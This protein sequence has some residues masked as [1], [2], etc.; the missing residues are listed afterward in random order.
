MAQFEIRAREGLG[1]LGKLQTKHGA[2]RTPLLMPVIHPG[3]A[4]IRANEMISEFGFQMVIT[5][6]YIINSHER[7]RE[8]ALA[9]G[10][11]ALLDIDCPIMTDSGTF[12][13]YFHDLPK[14][15]IDPI[16]IV[17]FQKEIRTDIGTIL[18][19][20]SAPDVG[21]EQVERDVD[22]SLERAKMSVGIKGEM[23]LAGTIQGGMYTNLREKS[24]QQ[25]GKLNFDVYPIGGV[26]PFMEMYRY[27][28]I[29]R[30]I[31][32]CK[33]YLPPDR[34]VHLFGCGHPML[35]AQAALLGCDLFDS[36]SY[37][38]FAESG[39]MLLTS[40]TVHL[41]GLSELP[42]EC[43]VCSTT[44]AD[45][46]KAL[47]KDERDAA[48]MRHNLY[49]SAAEIRR[50]RQAISDNKLFELTSLRARSH[51]ALLEA[52]E[53]M[54]EEM[55]LLYQQDPM[56]KTS[57]IFYT[58]PETVNRPEIVRFH[59]RIM[60]RYPYW[61]TD[62]IL[63]F[64]DSGGRPFSES[65][66]TIIDFVRKKPPQNLIVL[67]LTPMGVVPWELE[68]VHPAQQCIFPKKVDSNTLQIVENRLLEF[69]KS[70]KFKKIIWFSRE[71][72]TNLI[73]TRLSE[74]TDVIV[75]STASEAL[76]NVES[77]EIEENDWIQRKLR[78]ILRYQW[79]EEAAVL[80]DKGNLTAKISKSTGKIRYV[81]QDGHILFTMVPTNGLLTPTFQGGIEL[82]NLGIDGRYIVRIDDEVRE[83]VAKG[84]SALAKFVVT[85][86][87]KLIAGEECLVVDSEMNLLGVGRALLSGEEM[88]IF[89][90]GVAVNIRHS[91]DT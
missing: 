8:I 23:M 38:K 54:L 69:L 7:F 71:S 10:V 49:V 82:L 52:F 80:A 62:N 48:L 78:V 25:M 59:S 16:S 41:E 5:N 6:S 11:H 3:K 64:P 72:P 75:A 26:V 15:E 21:Y 14:E 90:R 76:E 74:M 56:A 34:P 20:F 4:I 45:D 66:S 33:K 73:L 65:A 22:L 53:T 30:I 67:F 32:A 9:N 39:R 70:M 86:D 29:V 43:P 13:M 40:G 57:S 88:L 77:A 79:G 42:C 1:R 50:V 58:G 61:E 17:E 37:A 24:A 46:L 89:K 2:V 28:D 31:Q 68:H 12:Q 55:N 27:T 36:A 18:D 19:V 87:S 51:P 47:S 60:D 63:I 35:F 83:F 85:A 84:K 91:R 81:S 44:T